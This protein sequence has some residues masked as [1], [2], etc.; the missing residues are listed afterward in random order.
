[1]GTGKTTVGRLL[2]KKLGYEFVDTDELIQ[3]R[4][5]LSIEEVFLQHGEAA[6]RQMEAEVALELGNRAGV[7]VSTGGRLMLD[8][9]NV[10]ALSRFGRVFCL[11]AT[12]DE[13]LSRLEEDK[14]HP[15]PLLQVPDPE[16]RI[17][18]LLQER[19]QGYARFPQVATNDKRPSDIIGD[20]I[21]LI[22][23]DPKRYIIRH[24]RPYEFIV[25]GG[26]LPFLRQLSDVT[27]P[28]AIIVSERVKSLYLASCGPVEHVITIPDGRQYKTLA[29][30][31]AIYTQLLDEKFDRSGTVV[32]LGGSTVG[33]I[34]G[35]VAGTYMRGV[36]FVQCPTSLLALADTSIGGKNGID[37]SHGRNLIGIIKE[38]NAVIADVATLQTLPYRDFISGM[39]E[40]IKH[41]LLA[42]SNLLQRV[43]EGQWTEGHIRMQLSLPELQALV[44]QSAQVKIAVVQADPYEHGRRTTLN[45]GHTFAYA[46]EQLSHFRI[47]HGDAV[48][49]GLVAAANLSA[50]MGFCSTE[51]QERIEGVLTHVG[52]P[53][54]IPQEL[55]AEEMLVAMETD[56]KRIGGRPRF[57]LIRDIGDVFVTDT[58]SAQAVIEMLNDL[59]V[60]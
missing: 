46:I 7:V 37:M 49:M 14:A 25:G 48:A 52:L 16:E 31:E 39:A 27:G 43:E 19:E 20:L 8:P 22:T 26:I 15:R 17:V 12:P 2:A 34:A 41:G 47:R 3:E 10:S 4:L 54:R 60:R 45:L 51:V 50:R 32:A 21:S 9:V 11:V 29:T 53:T 40:V 6:F 56:K 30:V 33:E 13:I 44:A 55:R 58:V 35:F 42:D 59:A 36:N 57:V 18:E 23:E 28:I 5:G 24:E 1:M 38:P